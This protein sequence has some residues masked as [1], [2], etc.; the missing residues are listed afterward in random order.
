MVLFRLL[1]AC[2]LAGMLAGCATL[3]YYAQAVSGELSI[4][5]NRRD[6]SKVIAD[7]K[8]PAAVRAKLTLALKARDFASRTLHLPDNDSYRTYVDL[9]RR[10]PVWVVYAAPPFSL[11]PITWCF[12]F[13]GCVPY[14]GYFSKD[15]ADAFAAQLNKQG[16]DVYVGGAPSYSTL[17]WFA[18]PVFS[19]MLRWNDAALAGLIFHELAHQLVYVKNDSSFNESFADTVQTVGIRRWLRAQGEPEALAA[20]EQG[21]AVERAFEDLVRETRTRLEKIY[22]A[23]LNAAAKRQRKAEAFAWLKARYARLVAQTGRDVYGEW[24]THPLNNASLQVITTYDQ[25]QPAF[26]RL[27]ACTGDDLPAFYAKVREIAALAPA[28][29]H[30]RL[31]ALA[32]ARVTPA[33]AR[34]RTPAT[35]AGEL[36]PAAN[37]CRMQP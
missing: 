14:R 2:A 7:P 28:A 26:E 23:P 25:W 9:D 22:A 4:L 33:S 35:T 30:A 19:N 11:T 3:G 29:R 34:R 18:D 36:R 6:I 17:G 12:L 32:P 31:R 15:A 5:T 8:T 20:Y 10:Y 27:L 24:F 16:N 1:V 13:A 21:L 37:G